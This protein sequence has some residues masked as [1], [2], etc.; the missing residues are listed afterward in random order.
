MKKRSP[1]P[2]DNSSETPTA[3]RQRRPKETRSQMIERLTNPLISLHEA[4]VILNVCASTLR[5]YS[6]SGVLPHER[7]SGGQRRFHLKQVLALLADRE[8]QRLYTRRRTRGRIRSSQLRV[9]AHKTGAPTSPQA[10]VLSERERREIEGRKVLEAA[11]ARLKA[12]PS[13]AAMQ[14]NQARDTPPARLPISRLAS[15][16]RA[17]MQADEAEHKAH[18][19]DD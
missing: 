16:G 13:Q 2:S 11:R 12:R 4:G 9:E 8:K 3:R 1:S 15:L 7:T 14:K 6:D 18:S 19:E 5:R 17:Q 10:P